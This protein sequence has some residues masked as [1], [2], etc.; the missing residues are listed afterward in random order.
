MGKHPHKKLSTGIRTEVGRGQREALPTNC[1]VFLFDPI[2]PLFPA[3]YFPEIG[4]IL[5]TRLQIRAQGS[6]PGLALREE[7]F[8]AAQLSRKKKKCVLPPPNKKNIK[9]N[10]KN[11]K[12]S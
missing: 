3:F 2:F 6:N 10:K 5:K 9:R 8:L 7:E 4:F 1:I 11:N 12:R